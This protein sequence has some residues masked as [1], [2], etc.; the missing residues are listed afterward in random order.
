MCALLNS[1]SLRCI[2]PPHSGREREIGGSYVTTHTH[3]HIHKHTYTYTHTSN[4][5]HYQGMRNRR[6]DMQRLLI[7]C[8]QLL[9]ILLFCIHLY[10]EG[11]HL[12]QLC[13]LLNVINP[14]LR[15]TGQVKLFYDPRKTG[16]VPLVETQLAKLE[17][18]NSVRHLL[19]LTAFFIQQ[20]GLPIL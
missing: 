1:P 8:L 3:T 17:R 7:K 16:V 12:Q 9:I 2:L 13:S 4:N 14:L 20:E 6:L 11:V 5:P 19:L 10:L 18:E 15:L